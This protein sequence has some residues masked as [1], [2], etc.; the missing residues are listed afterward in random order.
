M[1]ILIPIFLVAFASI[2]VVVGIAT[3]YFKSKQRNQIR[4]HAAQR[5][6][7]AG[8]ATNKHAPA[9]Q[10]EEDSGLTDLLKRFSFIDRL[11]L[12]IE[13][14]GQKTTSSKLILFLIVQAVVGFLLGSR[15][16]LLPAGLTGLLCRFARR[17]LPSS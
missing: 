9:R 2:L 4:L 11:D 10:S 16:S 14:S 7:F 12:I 8:G 1:A 17:L 13:Q 15:F 3:S 5:R 6:G